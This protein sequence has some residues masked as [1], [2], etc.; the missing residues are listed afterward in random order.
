M[1]DFDIHTKDPTLLF[2]DNDAA[3]QIAHNPTFHERIKHI[4][5]DCH[6]VREKVEDKTIKLLRIRFS[7]QLADMFTKPL[8]NTKLQSFLCKMGLKNIYSPSPSLGGIF[9]VIFIIYA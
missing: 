9:E 1:K 2:G 3:L 6:F 5:V 4:E 7:L 8:P